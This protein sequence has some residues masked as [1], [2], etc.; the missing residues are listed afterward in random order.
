V[1]AAGRVRAAADG[2]AAGVGVTS[3]VNTL[4]TRRGREHEVWTGRK[5]AYLSA[6]EL[7]QASAAGYEPDDAGVYLAGRDPRR[8]KPDEIRAIGHEP[9]SPM[10]AIR[11]KC[12]DCCAGSAHEVRLCV[13][14]ACP[15]W[16]FR[17]GKNPW[18]APISEERR[19]ALRERGV[20]LSG[21]RKINALGAG[22]APPATTL[23]AEALRSPEQRKIEA[24]PAVPRFARGAPR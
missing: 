13:A 19:E 17:T 14:M 22:I 10:E 15:S 4:L 18:R 21:Q 23:P 24:S 12:L 1:S 8:M 7:R 3:A 6:D 16:P 20:R 5:V 11:A 9:S 2:P